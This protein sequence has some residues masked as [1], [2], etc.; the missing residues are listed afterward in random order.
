[1]LTAGISFRNYPESFKLEQYI[2]PYILFFIFIL[3][4]VILPVITWVLKIY[5]LKTTYSFL[6]KTIIVLLILQM[7]DIV[8]AYIYRPNI[9]TLASHLVHLY[10]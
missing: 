8:I 9:S 4:I 7:G 5:H 2:P 10:L 6:I 1:M 3:S